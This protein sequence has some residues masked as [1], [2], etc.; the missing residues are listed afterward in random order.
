MMDGVRHCL[1]W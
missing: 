1:K